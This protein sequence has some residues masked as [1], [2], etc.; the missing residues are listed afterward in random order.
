MTVGGALKTA[1]R[2]M[3]EQLW[4]L[5]LLNFALA[6][7][8]LA[9]LLVVSYTRSGLLLLVG[10]GP[11]AAA[12]MHC[13]V[14]LQQTHEL[15]LRD[16]VVG[17]RLHWRR[18]L[19]LGA[20]LAVA[21][22]LVVGSVSFYAHR[23]WPVALLALY[24]AFMF[25]VWQVHVWPLAIARRGDE[26]REVLRAAATGLARRP[27]A[28]LALAFL[29]L[30]VNAVGAIGVLPVLTLTVAYSALAAAN[31]ALPRPTEEALP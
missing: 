21:V 3:Y 4:R 29:L 28:S 13:A 2:Q 8:V 30:L 26:L 22:L 24:L 9:I 12:L 19:L 16:G 11:F 7:V 23:A 10:L 25:G 27:F 20:I 14:T 17:L 1:L 18:G 15:S 6:G 31:F 5:A